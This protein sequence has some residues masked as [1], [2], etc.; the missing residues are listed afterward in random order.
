MVDKIALMVKASLKKTLPSFETGDI[1]RVSL[2]VQEGDKSRLQIFEGT[3]IRRR[4]QGTGASFTVLRDMRGDIVEKVFP[5]HSPSIE[6]VKVVK[7]GHVR[8]SR[9]YYLRKKKIGTA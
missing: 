2:R 5:L 8:R 3:V 9:L 6:K 7:K 4:G 1:V